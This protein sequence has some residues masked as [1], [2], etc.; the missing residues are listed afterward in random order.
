MRRYEKI[1]QRLMH[2]GKVVGFY[3]DIVKLPSGKVV[4][5]DLVKHKGAAAVVPVTD[6][7]NILLVKQYRNALDQETLEIPA[8]GIEPGETGLECVTREIEEETGYRAGRMEHLMTIITAIGFCDEKI[9]IYVAFDL[10]LSHQ[11]L[12]E[13]EFI[14]VQEYTP[15]QIKEMIFDGRIID[16]KTI[17]GVL[18]YLQKYHK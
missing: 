5:W 12:D 1:E 9:P 6:K 2:Q 11:N 14:D 4:T 10:K 8:G 17:S 13:D 16:A 7:G 3:E 18:G 15:E